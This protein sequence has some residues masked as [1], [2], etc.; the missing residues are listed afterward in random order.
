[1]TMKHS[2]L[3]ISAF[4]LAGAVLGLADAAIAQA[5]KATAPAPSAPAAP[6]A[7]QPAGGAADVVARVGTSEVTAADV[8]AIV[9]SLDGRQ[10]AALARDPTLLSQ[11]VRALLANRI[12][13][14]EAQAKK[15]DQQP[16]VVAQLERMKESLVIESYLQ[17]VSVPPEG[18]P[19]ESEIKTAYDANVAA[20]VVPRQ[21]H[22]AQVFIAVTREADKAAQDKARTK[23]DDVQSKLRQAGADFATI[24]KAQS[25]DSVTAERG[26]DIGWVTEA[27]MR[28]DIRT[29][30]VG[31]AKGA[32]SE[33]VRVDDGWIIVKLVDTKASY[34]RP[35]EEVR[36]AVAQRMRAERAELNRRAYMAELFKQNPPVI[37]EMALSKLLEQTPR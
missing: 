21:F 37:N 19:N 35:L 7:A 33:P 20:F 24:A 16:A 32:M 23:L 25:E 3:R 30:V 34:T 31:L 6:S 28:P 15:W 12:V 27:Q 9:A 5:P 4:L 26:G 8:R 14:K 36:E 1:M 10:Q 18:F 11:A 17:S 22:V 13:L 29:H 2:R